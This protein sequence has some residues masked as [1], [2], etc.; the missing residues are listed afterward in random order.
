MHLADE[1]VLRAVSRDVLDPEVA[2]A[3]RADTLK[4]ELA[5]LENRADPLRRGY[6][7]C[8]AALDHP[9]GRQGSDCVAQLPGNYRK[10]PANTGANTECFQGGVGVDS[11]PDF[12]RSVVAGLDLNQR[13]LGYEPFYF[14]PGKGDSIARLAEALTFRPFLA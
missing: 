11:D 10:R 7:R 13:P 5:R 4:N 1:V 9:A 14:R 2:V 3:G 6:C 8:R 12:Q